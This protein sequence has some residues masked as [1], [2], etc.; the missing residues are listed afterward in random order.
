M[1][2]RPGSSGAKKAEPSAFINKFLKTA[3][4]TVIK[5]KPSAEA[6]D[7][8]EVNTATPESK[9]LV[10]P[11]E[12]IMMVLQSIQDNVSMLVLH[13]T[14]R[15]LRSLC[16]DA[17]LEYQALSQL[18]AKPWWDD[19]YLKQICSLQDDELTEYGRLLWRDRMCGE[20]KHLRSDANSYKQAVGRIYR[21]M[22]CSGCKTR[23]PLYL[24]SYGE[25]QKASNVRVCIGRQGYFR[26]C[27]HVTL[28]FQRLEVAGTELEF[29][30]CAQ[31]ASHRLGK[32]SYSHDNCK[33]HR[34]VILGAEL[35]YHSVGVRS[36]FATCRMEWYQPVCLFWPVNMA[37]TDMQSS[38]HD[39]LVK[40]IP[41][42]MTEFIDINPP[43]TTCHHAGSSEFNVKR[44]S[45]MENQ[46]PSNSHRT[47]ATQSTCTSPDCEFRTSLLVESTRFEIRA[48]YKF[49]FTSATDPSWLRTLDPQSYLS[50]SDE[51]TR[52][53]MWC[54]NPGCATM[55]SGR[56]R[57]NL[58]RQQSAPSS[59]EQLLYKLPHT[60]R[61]MDQQ[62]S[63]KAKEAAPDSMF[64]KIPDEIIINIIYDID[65]RISFLMLRQT[66]SRLKRLCEDA[67]FK[68][69]LPAHWETDAQRP[70]PL[71]AKEGYVIS[72]EEDPEYCRTLGRDSMCGD[73]TKL[74]GDPVLYKK[75]VDRMYEA[76]WCSGCLAY[77]PAYLFSLAERQ[78]ED[79][80]QRVCIGRQGY[81]RLC[82][83]KT[84]EWRDIENYEK[85][86]PSDS[87]WERVKPC[88]YMRH[89]S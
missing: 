37:E 16:E 84:I 66:C 83:H 46:A 32:R 47:R 31:C 28:D 5:K 62:L 24:F 8:K 65:D 41:K 89:E 33:A 17:T 53:L 85:R 67:T 48:V 43:M 9:L 38:L 45:L 78:K 3:M 4:A 39:Q 30:D 21:T 71:Q 80:D 50:D 72:P 54:P 63:T 12:I 70:N 13:Q 88:L 77:H 52:G 60:N 35:Q 57:D 64:L 2:T 1:G 58:F 79:P 82:K 74:R 25:R 15:R 14:C 42:Y 22:R 87:W 61:Q 20:C 76:V 11:D 69:R 86:A 75:K 40:N 36:T 56:T 55:R 23:H 81:W 68:Y 26:F 18:D 7:V 51:L 44:V 10:L 6:E 19:P 59:W 27:K 29:V 73:C 49:S 34:R